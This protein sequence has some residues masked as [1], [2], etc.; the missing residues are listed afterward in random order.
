MSSRQ[1]RFYSRSQLT[2]IVST[3]SSV[4]LMWAAGTPLCQ[5]GG[6]SFTGTN[7]LATDRANSVLTAAQGSALK[8]TSYCAY[9]N[10]PFGSLP[11][12]LGYNGE[13]IDA[14]GMSLLGCGERGYSTRFRRFFSPDR[15]SIFLAEN[16]NSYAYT[17]GDPINHNDPSGNFRSPIAIYREWKAGRA[18][19]KLSKELIRG[20]DNKSELEYQ[21]RDAK[22]RDNQ[23]PEEIK[24]LNENIKTTSNELTTLQREMEQL[25]DTVFYKKRGLTIEAEYVYSAYAKAVDK[26]KKLA[27][28]LDSMLNR[29][30]DLQNEKSQ[31]SA[32]KHRAL[33]NEQ[34]IKENRKRLQHLQEKYPELAAKA[35]RKMA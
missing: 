19:A 14:F 1:L 8:S 10:N 2:S 7:L 24:T 16:L 12:V 27:A 29:R 33:H 6:S 23:R 4:R 20:I 17:A 30:S 25:D 13:Y 15:A 22:R 26:E 34:A 5:L 35:L 18:L 32:A 21:I 28:S 31:V 11:V 3:G 9:G